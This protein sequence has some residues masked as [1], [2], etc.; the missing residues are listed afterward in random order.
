M[1]DF[2]LSDC[3]GAYNKPITVHAVRCLLFSPSILSSVLYA[4][5]SIARHKIASVN[6][7]FAKQ[8]KRTPQISNKENKSSKI[9]YNY[10][11]VHYVQLDLSW[12]FVFTFVSMQIVNSNDASTATCRTYSQKSRSSEAGEF[13]IP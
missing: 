13:I 1:S 8:R 3:P 12:N 4:N 7:F 10:L 2:A 6:G 5:M 9:S 11:F